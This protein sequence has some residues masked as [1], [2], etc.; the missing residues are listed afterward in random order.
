V[1][2]LDN[3][4]EELDNFA[5]Q[6]V[7]DAVSN[8]ESSGKVD[9]GKLKNSVKNDGTKISK[10]SVEIRLRLLPYGA[11][12]DKGVRGVGG[13]RKQTSAFKRTNNK[14]KLWKQKGGNSPYSFKEG[15]KPSVKHFIDWSNKRGLSPYAVRESVYHQGIE[16]NR[17]LEKAVNKNLPFL[18][19]K[20]I[21]A[22]GLDV[23]NTL[24]T[25]IKSNFKNVCWKYQKNSKLKCYAVKRK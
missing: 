10:N 24:N 6:I 4:K 14:G 9:T 25:I 3:L 11:F 15:R 17:F 22:F 20:I 8:L 5:N 21:D 7:K 16:P 19:E 2:K 23:Q 18:N 1:L 13:V 12:V